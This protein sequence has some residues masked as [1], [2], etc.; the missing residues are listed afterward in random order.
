MTQIQHRIAEVLAGGVKMT[1]GQII[2]ATGLTVDQVRY[3]ISSVA[4]S[5]VA[6]GGRGALWALKAYCLEPR[7]EPASEKIKAVLEAARSDGAY[8]KQIVARAKVSQSQVKIWLA[9]GFA[10]GVF[11]WH[12]DRSMRS[13]AR[14]RWYLAEHKPAQAPAPEVW[15]KKPKNKAGLVSVKKLPPACTPKHVKAQWKADHGVV[16][17]G[18]VTICLSGRDERFTVKLQPGYVSPLDPNDCRPWARAAT[19]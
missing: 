16:V 8:V 9:R 13:S 2:A 10:D 4:R 15:T 17:G 14:R 12:R 19:A 3:H 6:S 1:R 11:A 5:D 7:P 18:K